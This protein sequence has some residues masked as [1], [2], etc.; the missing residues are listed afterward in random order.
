MVTHARLLAAST[1]LL[2]GSLL[3]AQDLLA[4]TWNGAIKLVN[5][6]TGAVTPLGPGLSGQN[7]LA[8]ASNG[9][10]WSQQR[11]STSS[12]YFTRIDPGT[13]IATPVHYTSADIRGLASGPGTW[14]YGIQNGTS[15]VTDSLVR[16]DTASGSVQTIGSTGFDG[17]QGLA[18]HLGV[19]YAWDVFSGLLIVDQ[20]TGAASDPF[21]LVSGPTYQ[22]SL[23]SHRD[24]RLLLGGGDS[25]G[26]DQL[27][28]LDVTNGTATLIGNMVGAT[29]VRGLEPLDASAAPFGTG[30]NG[31]HGPVVLSVTGSLQAGGSLM[32]VSSNHEPNTLGA[33]VL[34]LSTTLYQAHALPLLLDP[35]LG[36]TNCTLYASIDASVLVFTGT[37][38]PASLQFGLPL[39]G[40]AAG[41]RFHLQH[42]CF[43][44]VPGNL[45]FSNGIAVQVR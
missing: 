42:V 28:S 4:V 15:T 44:P 19:L 2:A 22:Q 30:C 29:D 6:Y 5:S 17:I 25:N 11:L 34:G 7:C 33:V 8:R 12:Y 41:A 45:S 23:C 38:T 10:F 20:L 26:T 9:T 14:L 21:P 3:P 1:A 39:T 13:G 27:F 24:G 16:F 18:M 40:A 32:S 37:T 35:L 31:V 36:T 43:E